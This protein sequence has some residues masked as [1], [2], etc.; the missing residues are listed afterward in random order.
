[1]TSKIAGPKL[2]AYGVSLPAVYVV[3]V[4]VVALLLAI[5]RKIHRAYNRTRDSNFALDGLMGFD[6][7]AMNSTI[8]VN[9]VGVLIFAQGS[10]H[11]FNCLLHAQSQS[12]CSKK[13]SY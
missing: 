5:N 7:Q 12:G 1:M 3:W 10:L 2:D 13:L 11:L 6:L 8:P 9:C 4:G